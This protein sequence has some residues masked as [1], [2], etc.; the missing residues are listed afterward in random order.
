MYSC[1]KNCPLVPDYKLTEELNSFHYC[2]PDLILGQQF[3]EKYSLTR[4]KVP[5]DAEKRPLNDYCP[6]TQLKNL[7]QGCGSAIL[8]FRKENHDHPHASVTIIPIDENNT[9]VKIMEKID[10]FAEEC[11]G[12]R[13]PLY[14][15]SSSK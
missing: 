10:N 8:S 4:D 15:H 6:R 5:S 13:P 12:G 1:Q 7:F 14:C 9:K 3:D 2:H 11:T